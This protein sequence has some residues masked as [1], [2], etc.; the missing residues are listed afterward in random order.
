MVDVAGFVTSYTEVEPD[1]RND[2]L[3]KEFSI[4]MKSF[5]SA[6]RWYFC[7]LLHDLRYYFD[8]KLL[9]NL[10]FW[11]VRGCKFIIILL[12][13]NAILQVLLKTAAQV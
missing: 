3:H 7:H 8:C 1:E 12:C 9:V 11:F 13:Y 6:H 5:T 2:I 4:V 10:I